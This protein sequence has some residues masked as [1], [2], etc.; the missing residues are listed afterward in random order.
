MNGH[1]QVVKYL[2][3][4]GDD[5]HEKYHYHYL[6]TLAKER[7]DYRMIRGLKALQS[8]QRYKRIYQ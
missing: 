1:L 2:V 4:Q 3:E 8:T 5:I 6:L 7:K